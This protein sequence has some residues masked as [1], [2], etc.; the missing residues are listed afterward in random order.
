MNAG[1]FPLLF[2]FRQT[3]IFFLTQNPGFILWVVGSKFKG[4]KYKHYAW[5][6]FPNQYL[7]KNLSHILVFQMVY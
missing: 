6:E 5:V 3:E 7:L 1:G 4:E 2:V